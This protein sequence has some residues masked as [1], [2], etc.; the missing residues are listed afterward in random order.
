M[1]DSAQV[2]HLKL[3]IADQTEIINT[4]RLE[5]AKLRTERRW[6][7]GQRWHFAFYLLLHDLWPFSK[8]NW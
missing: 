5:L 1:E 7:A 3:V 8:F 2:A 4:Q 6:I